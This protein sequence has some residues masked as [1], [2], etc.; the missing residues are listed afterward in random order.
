M[1]YLNSIDKL[2]YHFKLMHVNARNKC[3]YVLTSN[4]PVSSKRYR[5]LIKSFRNLQ[6]VED[7]EIVFISDDFLARQIGI[8][9]DKFL[10]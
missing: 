7:V 10:K 3:I 8:C 4:L 9:R 6:N 1:F 5:N 2:P